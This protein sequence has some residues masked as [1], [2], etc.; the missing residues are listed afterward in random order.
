MLGQATTAEPPIWNSLEIAKLFLS[1]ATPLTVAIVGY[2]LSKVLKRIEDLQWANRRVIDKR[3]EL[4]DA[5]VPKLNDLLCF[6]LYV[7]AWKE[8]SP[9]DIV[10]LKR[11][12]DKLAYVAAPLFPSDFLARYSKL[13]GLCFSMYNEWGTDAKLRTLVHRRKQALGSGWQADWDRLF[14]ENDACEPE[15]VKQAYAQFTAYLARALGVNLSPSPRLP[16]EVP[17]NY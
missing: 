15:E 6:Y 12:L 7:G 3:I 16:V 4:Y 17:W 10:K 2:G 1:L 9:P 5:I 14:A 11:D 13:I 8:I